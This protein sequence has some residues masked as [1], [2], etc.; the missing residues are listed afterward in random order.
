MNITNI[1]WMKNLKSTGSDIPYYTWKGKYFSIIG[2]RN[3]HRCNILRAS[4]PSGFFKS[5]KIVDVGCNLGRMCHFAVERGASSAKGFEYDIKTFIAANNIVTMEKL[6]NEITIVNQDLSLKEIKE[7][8]D[9]AI[10]FSVLHHINPRKFIMKFLNNNINESIIIE[11]TFSEFPYN[12]SYDDSEIRWNFNDNDRMI[13]FL[14]SSLPNFKNYKLLG[15]SER[16]R[17]MMLFSKKSL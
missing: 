13:S 6:Q 5:K 15:V 12:S 1:E 8:F 17:L 2:E 3:D 11:S 9:I 16:N 7:D 10:C 14:K 4:L